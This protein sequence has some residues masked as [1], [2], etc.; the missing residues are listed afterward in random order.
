[1]IDPTD[2]YVLKVNPVDVPLGLPLI[3]GLSGFSDAGGTISQVSESIFATFD[4][5][6][7]VEFSNDE[8]LDYRSRRPVLY[9]EKDHIVSY[10]PL[11]LGIYLVTDDSGNP[12][13]FLHGYEPDFKWEAFVTALRDVFDLFAVSSLT[14]VHSIPFPVPHTKPVGVTV[15]GNRTDL[16]NSLSEWKPST[17][18]PGNVLHLIEWQMAN[19]GLPL[20]G[21]VMLVPHYLGDSEYPLAAITA[22][23]HI[24]T[25]T[26]L[27]FRTD[28]LRDEQAR[29]I[30]KLDKQV[31]ENQELQRIIASLE[32]GYLSGEAGPGRP[33]IQ[34]PPVQ[35][36]SADEIAA[37]LEDYLANRSRNELNDDEGGSQL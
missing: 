7:V 17:T 2:L 36:P 27:V 10:D 13:L 34:K 6:L 37:E 18:V 26:G 15:T 21:F 3:A 12:F 25:A 35:V 24:S 11:V 28:P 22:F 1:M 33:Q 30:R 32:Q 23:Q 14:W 16:I 4:S 31:E 5:K 8:L 29:F 19:S 20:T 9:F